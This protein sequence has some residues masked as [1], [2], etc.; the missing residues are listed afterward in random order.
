MRLADFRK[1]LAQVWGRRPGGRRHPSPTPS[2]AP[3]T[4]ATPTP[5]DEPGAEAAEPEPDSEPAEPAPDDEAVDEAAIDEPAET[6][7]DD[8][9]A[10][11]VAAGGPASELDGGASGDE[12]G[13]EEGETGGR[14]AAGGG[15]FGGRLGG[16]V[17]W[18]QRWRRRW[19]P[20][21][22]T[23]AFALAG[24]IVALLLTGR[25]KADVGPFDATI[26]ARPSLVGDTTV[27]L[28]PLGTIVL[29]THVAPVALDIRA[30]QI[31]LEEAE[32]IAENPETIDRLG[33]DV[34]DDVRD[35]VRRLALRCVV[36]AVIGGVIGALLSRLSWRTAATGGAMGALLVTAVGAE[37]ATTFDAN[38]VAEPKYTGLLRSAPAAV[39]DVEEIVERYGQYR[40]QLRELVANVVTLYLAADDL[41][42]FEP[43]G[44]TIRLLHVSDIHLNLQAFDLMRQVIEPFGVDAVVDTGDIVDWGTPPESQLVGEIGRLDVPYV[45]VRGNHDSRRTQEA[46]ADQPNAVVLD[47]DSAEVAG[48]RIWGVGD[49]RYTPDK[50]QP[51]GGPSEQEA[52]EEFAPELAEMLAEDEAESGEAD[53]LMVHDRR[54]AADVGGEVPLVLTGHNHQ[55]R[56]SRLGDDDETVLLTEGSTGGAG[57]RGL[58][59]EEP[60]PLVA[61]VLYLDPDTRQLVAYDRISLQ[62]FGETGVTIDRHIITPDTDSSDSDSTTT[63]TSD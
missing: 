1:R 42:A 52:A 55:P 47:G 35:A 51:A 61:S 15:R 40:A 48:L 62:G 56:E 22:R 43:D 50:D 36:V 29:D 31:G 38:A 44:D 18:G 63:T 14:A 53:V 49:P 6:S 27:R 32:R 2:P 41:P 37:A 26:A 5:D 3:T 21:L 30:D 9:P 59:G 13:A 28:A 11:E 46:V 20:R 34:A 45:F 4:S 12:P 17:T 58:Q 10:G 24:A 33:D 19:G 39:G 25:V 57:L 54:A 16:A 60:E 7:S 8:E 23:M